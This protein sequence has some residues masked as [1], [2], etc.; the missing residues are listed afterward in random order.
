MTVESKW[1]K[2]DSGLLIQKMNLMHV[3]EKSVFEG[4]WSIRKT[5]R[6]AIENYR[7]KFNVYSYTWIVYEARILRV[8]VLNKHLV[9]V[10][11]SL[12]PGIMNETREALPSQSKD[13]FYYI[14]QRPLN[15]GINQT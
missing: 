14:L 4:Q 3:I 11:S 15:K 2:R 13:F 12:S 7:E 1:S 6:P 8:T 9:A 5:S 10:C